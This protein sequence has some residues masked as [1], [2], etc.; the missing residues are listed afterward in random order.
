MSA[1]QPVTEAFCEGKE[2]FTSKPLA[3]RVRG[4]MR[5]KNMVVYKCEHCHC[6]HIGADLG[7]H[8]KKKGFMKRVWV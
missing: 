7:Q 6:W 2:R 1:A 4:R 8:R 3:N 5:H